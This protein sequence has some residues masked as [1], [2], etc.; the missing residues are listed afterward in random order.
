MLVVTTTV[1]MLYWVHGHTS[2]LR[3][4]VSLHLVLVVAGSGLEKRLLGS[5]ASRD[6]ANHGSARRRDELLASAWE[7][8]PRDAS[9][10]VVGHDDSVGSTRPRQRG[11]V[12][13]VPLDVANHGT[14]RHASHVLDVSNGKRRLLSRVDELSG[15]KSL[16]GDEGLL[17]V[18]VPDG[19]PEGDLGERRAAAW[20]VDDLVDHSLDVALLLRV[21][22]AAELGGALPRA[23]DRLENTAITLTLSTDD[24]THLAELRTHCLH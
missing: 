2:N 11:P 6:L 21:V 3:P 4:A 24:A 13:C 22:E 18:L 17:L 23:V 1:R 9:V 5:S 10:D 19:V 8:D 12:S 14:L 15:V 16:R 7:L 20:V